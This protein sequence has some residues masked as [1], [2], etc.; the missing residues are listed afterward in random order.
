MKQWI[1]KYIWKTMSDITF[2]LLDIEN[3]QWCFSI[4]FILLYII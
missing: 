4:I 3:V 1:K 2:R